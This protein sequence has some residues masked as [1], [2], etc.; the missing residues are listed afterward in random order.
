MLLETIIISSI[1]SRDVLDNGFQIICYQQSI[2]NIPVWDSKSKLVLDQYDN[3][4]YI[5]DNTKTIK[6]ILNKSYEITNDHLKYYYFI[7]D[8]HEA[9]L[10]QYIQDDTNHIAQLINTHND[11]ILFQQSILFSCRSDIQVLVYPFGPAPGIPHKYTIPN[12]WQ[13]SYIERNLV[14]IHPEWI[15]EDNITQGNNADGY[16]FLHFTHD[17]SP[18]T[19][20]TDLTNFNSNINFDDPSYTYMDNVNINTFYLCNWWHDELYKFGF[21]E[22][23]G[24][25]QEDN[26]GR[27]GVGGDRIKFMNTWTI[28]SSNN[29]FTSVSPIDGTLCG[30]AV[31]PF[32]SNGKERHS[33]F[34]REIVLHELTHGSTARLIGSFSDT[35]Q[36]RALHEGWS[37][38]VSIILSV[39]KNDLK[40]KVVIP[41]GWATYQFNNN[42]ALVDNYFFSIRRYGIST[43]TS[44]NNLTLND[45]NNIQFDVD[46][47]IPRSSLHLPNDSAH[48]R[49]EIWSVTLWEIFVSLVHMYGLIGGK[50]IMMDL[51]ITGQKLCP[52]NP[53]FLEARDTIILADKILY[54]D[55]HRVLLHNAFAKRGMGIGAVVPQ[56][57]TCYPIIESFI[58]PDW[59][60]YNQDGIKNS[61][62]V[63]EFLNDYQQ[64][65]IKCDLNLDNKINSI[66]IITFLGL[67]NK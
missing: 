45:L 50:D 7:N 44:I 62:D 24:N 12:G 39:N 26:F 56:D 43:D 34:D 41:G 4:I 38:I 61:L 29:A 64:Q 46:S 9:I 3:P 47:S 19:Y 27:G 63:V 18:I 66:D 17:S 15:T 10:S 22:E 53:T 42:N 5:V 20:H 54:N 51:I 48:S 65:N 40:D 35:E 28:L 60:D 11:E 16:V 6:S 31:L 37:D 57:G 58:Y 52:P 33:G 55:S 49:G 8:K 14:D 36:F 23:W 21:T 59:G 13:A 1:L 67:F 30:V 25:F 32:I 2:N